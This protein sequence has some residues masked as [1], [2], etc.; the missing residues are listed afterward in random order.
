VVAPAKSLR[1]GPSMGAWWPG[2]RI[3]RRDVALLAGSVLLQLV[4]GLLFGHAYD[5]PIF[6]ATG[7]L[8]ATGQNPYL[9]QDLSGLFHNNAFRSLTSVGYPPPW[10]LVLGGI[11]RLIGSATPNLLV[12]NLAIKIPIIAANVGLAFLVAQLLVKQGAVAAV[13]RKAW[14]FMLWNPFLLV[15]SAAWGQFDSVVAL[16]ALGSLALL[17]SKKPDLSAILLGLAVSAKPS[18]LPLLLVPWMVLGSRPGWPRG[19][20]YILL[21]ASLIFFCVGPFVFFG[22][23]PET[24]LRNWNAHL[25]VGGGMSLLTFR[26]LTNGT[27]VLEGAWQILGVMWLP[28]VVVAAWSLR[29]RVRQQRGSL[30]ASTVLVLV[31]LL[32]RAWV[33]EPNILLVLPLVVILVGLGDL[34][35]PALTALWMLPL[36]FGLFNTSLVQLVFPSMP[37]AL[38]R[39]LDQADIF[40]TARLVSCTVVVLTWQVVGW[41]IVIR[42]LRRPAREAA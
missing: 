29:S 24:I 17:D 23:S 16:L 3:S 25:I 38:A 39:L 6:M 8:A 40:R 5:M 9:A 15:A 34:P 21:A 12:Y 18:A 37:E 28:A 27:Y 30:V 22:W 1:S 14:V 31:F 11:W 42:L 36:V 2:G 26:V 32:T 33:S 41:W 19:R 35:S 7:Y 13:V 20:Y 4:L 10:P